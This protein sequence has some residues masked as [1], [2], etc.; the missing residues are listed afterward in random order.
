MKKNE[1]AALSSPNRLPKNS[2]FGFTTNYNFPNVSKLI[3]QAH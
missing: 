3:A 2:F 1:Q